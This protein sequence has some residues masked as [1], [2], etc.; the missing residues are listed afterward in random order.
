M[1][2]KVFHL[3]LDFAFCRKDTQCAEL[4]NAGRYMH[5]ADVETEADWEPEQKLEHAF[6]RTNSVHG[7]WGLHHDV[8]LAVAGG[9]FR[10]TSIGDVVELDGVP[11]MVASAGFVKLPGC[12]G[13][14]PDTGRV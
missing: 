14:D 4:W 5:V 7:Y 11:W 12:D 3:P 13:S 6:T 9:R 10:S 2:T 1:S 8:T